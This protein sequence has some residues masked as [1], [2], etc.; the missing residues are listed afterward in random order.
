MILLCADRW[1][2]IDENEWLNY[3]RLKQSHLPETYLELA[4]PLFAVT[5]FISEAVLLMRF[6]SC[7]S[8]K[9]YKISFID[10]NTLLNAVSGL[11]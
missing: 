1:L 5:S 11:Q 2:L 9:C 6:K 7:L 10:A 8:T 3:H 4:F